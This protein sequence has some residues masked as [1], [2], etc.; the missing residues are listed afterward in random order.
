MVAAVQKEDPFCQQV[1]KD[2]KQDP[3]T[4]QSYQCA[5]NGILLYKGRL[6]V[7]NQR[8]LVH[9]LLRLHHNEPIAGHWG[10]QKTMEL[11]QRKFKWE[12]IR[13]DIDEYIQACPICQGNSA[14]RH[15][16]YG[17]LEPL[18]PPTRPW[19]EISMDL[20]TQLPV[21]LRG[22]KE[23][24]A[25]LIIVDRYTKMAVF[26][27]ICNEINAADLAELIYKEVELR[28]GAPSGIVSDR[29]SH[30]TSKFWAEMCYYSMIKRRMSTAFHAQTNRQ[31]EILNRIIEN[32]LQAF[33]NLKQ[34]NW[35]K[36][37]PTA[38]FA[39]NNSMNH[40]LRMSP[41]KAMY[42]Y[43]PEFHV[44]VA[45]DIP[46]GEIPAARDRVEKLYKLRMALREQLLK[47]QERQMRYYNQR[48]TPI[49]FK[50]GSL[51]K[52]STCNLKLKDKKLQPRFV[53][54]FRV[55]E[56]VGTQAYRLALP[57]Q[58][59]RLHDVFPVQ[60][61]E[62]YHQ[63][64]DQREGD[65]K[66]PLPELEDD[67]NKYKL[68]EIRDKKTIRGQIHY[69]VKWTGWPSEYNQWVPEDGM[70]NAHEMVRSFEKSRRG[71][72]RHDNDTIVGKTKQV[73][74]TEK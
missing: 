34:I 1:V 42:G 2:L 40:T 17:K 63:S 50:R 41:F 18:P 54:P 25:I 55:T 62:R 46:R 49:E 14:P 73:K 48:H 33:I 51:V 58:Y 70:A 39:Y 22:T 20:I 26:L 69:L 68:K 56:V 27:P 38:A 72:R 59:A 10:I 30:I 36:L 35:A 21:S 67:P 24:N 12:G 61:L 28:F 43:D 32:Y 29:D 65:I 71:K 66:L 13:L 8:S 60:L 19:K 7:P 11:V 15:K 64:D 6:V 9:E 23:Y 37:L 57:E 16:P 45:D 74:R 53:G 31:T 4:R 5:G 44:D 52:L 3:V 47:A